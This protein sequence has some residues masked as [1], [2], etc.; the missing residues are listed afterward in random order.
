MYPTLVELCGLPTNPRND[1]RSFAQLLRNPGMPWNHPTLTTNTFRNHRIYDG[2]YS[3]S[4]DER[5]GVEQL[6]DNHKDPMQWTNLAGDPQYVEIEARLK[7]HVP[8]TNEPE[9]PSN[10]E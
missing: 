1:G 8:E 5:R 6:Y 3:Y 10:E 7:A 2:R 9:S 4:I